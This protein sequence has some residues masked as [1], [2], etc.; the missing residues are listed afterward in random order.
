MPVYLVQHGE[1]F[2]K[3]ENPLRCLTENG[4]SGIEKI[5]A[6]LQSVRVPV[7]LVYHS[8]KTRARETAEIFTK[9]FHPTPE[10]LEKNGLAPKDT[11]EPWQKLLSET[12]NNVMIVGH[13]PFMAR[14]SALLL[15]GKPSYES[16]TFRYGCVVCLEKRNASVWKLTWMLIP[17]LLP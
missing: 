11:V 9:A 16:I 3:E 1:A 5:A 15:T 13:L 8:G 6:F 2:S 4:K 7:N 17:E 12:E 10:I 14:L